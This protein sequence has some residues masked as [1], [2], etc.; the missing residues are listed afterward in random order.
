M[1]LKPLLVIVPELMMYEVYPFTSL[2]VLLIKDHHHPLRNI[3]KC[4]GQCD[5]EGISLVAVERDTGGKTL[6]K[7]MERYGH[8]KKEGAVERG[9]VCMVFLLSYS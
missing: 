5:G 1:K 8:Y 9:V 3:L 4:D 2:M 7:F 6:R